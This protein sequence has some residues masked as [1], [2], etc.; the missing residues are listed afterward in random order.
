MAGLMAKIQEIS[1]KRKAG[2]RRLDESEEDNENMLVQTYSDEEIEDLDALKESAEDVGGYVKEVQDEDGE[3]EYEVC[4][5]HLEARNF[6]NI[7]TEKGAFK[8]DE[9]DDETLEEKAK[10]RKR[11]KARFNEEGE[12]DE[13][14]ENLEDEP[15]EEKA[16]FRRKS[17]RLNEGV[18]SKGRKD[19]SFLNEE[20]DELEED[21]EPLEEKDKSKKRRKA[22]FNEEDELEEDDVEVNDYEDDTLEEKAKSRK[23][24]ARFNEEDDILRNDIGDEEEDDETDEDEPLEEKAKSKKRRKAKF[25]EEDDNETDE[26]D[27]NLEEC[28]L[29]EFRKQNVFTKIA[30]RPVDEAEYTKEEYQ[31]MADELR[32]VADDLEDGDFDDTSRLQAIRDLMPNVGKLRAGISVNE[33][34]EDDIDEDGD[35]TVTGFLYFKSEN[36]KHK[37]VPSFQKIYY[38]DEDGKIQYFG[39]YNEDKIAKYYGVKVEELINVL[40]YEITNESIDEVDR[41][42]SK[43]VKSG[44][45]ILGMYFSDKSDMDKCPTM[46]KILKNKYKVKDKYITY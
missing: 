10:S 31:A 19:M 30:N 15:L 34:E 5:P 38:K 25:N 41:L 8:T 14:D 28:G 33:E 4:V 3:T 7:A 35:E 18:V 39:P 22:K 26:D 20:D 21:D 46:I 6:E 11:R 12:T 17:R 42:C 32:R 13:D 16:R 27:E 43:L 29:S 9:E 45:T 40:E 37:K 44:A 23:R 1:K 36:P 2:F 24:R